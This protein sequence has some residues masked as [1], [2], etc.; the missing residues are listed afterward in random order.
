[1]AAELGADVGAVRF[2]ALGYRSCEH[3]NPPETRRDFL[4][5]RQH[6]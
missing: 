1:L 5:N 2:K 4:K 6:I 3:P